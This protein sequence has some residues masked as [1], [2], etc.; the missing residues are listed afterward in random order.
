MSTCG[1]R[2]QAATPAPRSPTPPLLITSRMLAARKPPMGHD[3]S[4]NKG[5]SRASILEHPCLSL[6]LI[7]STTADLCPTVESV[8][9]NL[10]SASSD[11]APAI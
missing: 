7:C 6:G 10:G 2:E 3:I 8:S 9:F 4:Q 11:V 5:I 1:P